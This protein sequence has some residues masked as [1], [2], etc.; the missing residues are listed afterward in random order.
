LVLVGCAQGPA[1][2]GQ[3]QTVVSGLVNKP[4]TIG[5]FRPGFSQWVLR[6]SNTGGATGTAGTGGPGGAGQFSFI[7]S[8]GTGATGGTGGPVVPV[9]GDWN[10]D[11]QTTI[12]VFRPAG[13]P[14]NPPGA[15]RWLLRNFNN[16]GPA[17][18]DLTYGGPGDLPVAGDW[19]GNGTVT[20][21]VYRPAGSPLNP[22]T[23]A[24]FLL[25]NSN[26]PGNPDISVQHGYAGDLPVVGDW[27]G[28][29]T[30]TMGI[31]R[32][33]TN[34]WF[35]R[36]SFDA[37]GPPDPLP[38]SFGFSE[39][40]EQPVVGDWDGNGTVTVG[41]FR[42]GSPAFWLLRNSND[43]GIP[44]LNFPFGGS[45]DR[46]VVGGWTFFLP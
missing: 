44:H 20:I 43:A 3:Q 4:T 32:P 8:G 33:S 29:G 22:T 2:D 24:Y 26:T 27:D 21:G 13:S 28:N 37:G 25:R 5:V 1:A 11:L 7:Y 17:N 10:G 19:D 36:N 31:F 46:P 40:G 42:P 30:T 45:G 34:T 39:I 12:G 18:V 23:D 9:A 41:V 15:A 14:G 16:A 35:L 38:F 6:T